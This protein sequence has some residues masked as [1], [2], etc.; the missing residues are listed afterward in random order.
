MITDPLAS[1]RIDVW[2][3][4]ITGARYTLASGQDLIEI[5]NCGLAAGDLRRYRIAT[6]APASTEPASAHP[7]ADSRPAVDNVPRLHT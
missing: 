2:D 1:P 7:S 4:R 5:T 6:L 3:F